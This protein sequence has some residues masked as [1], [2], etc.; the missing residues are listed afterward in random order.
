MWANPHDYARIDIIDGKRGPWMH[1][2]ARHTQE[3]CNF[4]TPQDVLNIEHDTTTDYE[5]YTGL[6]DP[7]DTK[8]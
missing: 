7:S 5:P 3:V 1:L 2:W 6:L 8:P 4:P